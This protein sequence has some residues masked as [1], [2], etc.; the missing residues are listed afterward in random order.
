MKTL[1]S[2]LQVGRN[3]HQGNQ[4]TV[5]EFLLL[6]LSNRAEQQK[7]LFVL[8]LGMYLVTVS[9]NGL[10]ILAIGLDSYLHTPMYLFLANLSF[11]DLSS[12]STSVPNMLMNIQTKS[13]SISYESCITQMYFSI[14]FVVIDN[15]L[16]GVMAYDRFVAICHPL[17]Y[18]TIMKPRLCILL[19]V[20]PWVLSN[21]VALTHTLLLLPLLFC[22]SNALP[23]FFCDLA[24][25]LRLSCS[26]TVVN[27]LVLL[28]V[29][30]SVITFPFSLILF[31]YVRIVRA[32]L[33]LSC[34]EGK[35]K[36]FSTC[37]SH[38]TV[39]LLFYG[40]IV[41][42]Y[43][44]PSFTHPDDRD[45]I[46]AVLFTVVA[47]MMNPFIYSLRNKDMKGALRKLI[48]RK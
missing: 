16:L 5:S 42:V 47:P 14:A 36:A 28:V 29:G 32:V 38:L 26:D 11:A 34:T 12:I 10:I 4:T 27:E 44:C 37:G 9:G 15:F 2:F 20:I 43:F 39:V 35:W 46:G 31:S 17:S 3:M 21:A 18:T 8:F 23:H 7:L 48:C 25:L 24:P 41:G 40:T 6:G 30:L 13:Q 45:Q 1:C 19:T 22:D 33:R